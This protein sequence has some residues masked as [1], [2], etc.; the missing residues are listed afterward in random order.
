MKCK[1]IIFFIVFIVFICL[2]SFQVKA[3]E[4]SQSDE[5]HV[6]GAQV[7]SSG[8]AGIRFVGSVGEYDTSNVKTY[9]LILAYGKTE[10]EI[11]ID[12]VVNDKEVFC[13]ETDSVN[14]NGYYYVTLYDIP[15]TQYDVN[16]SAR[17]YV[18]DA[19]G[20]IIY[21]ASH[22]ARSLD[23]VVFKAYQ[24]NDRSD[25]VCE[26]YKLIE[27]L[28]EVDLV[29][30]GTVVTGYNGSREIIAIPE[31]VTEIGYGAFNGCETITNIGLPNNITSIGQY[32]FKNCIS[33]QSLTSLS[34]VESIGSYAFDECTSLT[35][36]YYKGT[37]EQW[38]NITFGNIDS[39]P[40]VYA[41]HF[42]MLDENNEWYEVT[43]IV[44]PE[45]VTEISKYAFSGFDNLISIEIPSSVTNI[46]RSAF[47]NC[48]SLINVKFEENSKLTSIGNYAFYACESLTNIEIP[49][50]VTNIGQS[51]FSNCAS[52]T[53]I[54]IPSSVTS[55]GNYAFKNCT[56]L[57]SVK[58]EDNSKLT[59]IGNYAFENCA[60]LINV[61]F[62]ENNILT[63][64]GDYAFRDCTGLTS[65][66]IPSSVI[67]IGSSAFYNCG[68]LINVYYKG[69]I[70]GWNAIT[71]ADA[72]ANP[73]YYA[74]NLYTLDENGE[75]V[76][77][78]QN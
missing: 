30:I 44:I 45:T 52:L 32:A 58:F 74:Q 50:S 4:L 6:I 49:S 8:N 72:Y 46:G 67:S 27:E 10:E 19:D 76:L 70:E 75:W 28:T 63:S 9:G 60:S 40:M 71:F 53:N 65:I 17:A 59:S 36:V 13:C 33:L 47:E 34:K 29:Y 51:T 3:N 23:E 14:E 18:K 78:I 43:E 64:I 16:V 31:K 62:E 5:I 41:S 39:Y 25:F 21:G 15:S 7:R 61:K 35:N 66:E 24:D 22:I 1:R 57:I 11:Y 37:M 73:M 55:I 42:Y 68:E 48:A 77:S 69:T 38:F 56:S 26:V 20:N 12:S 2:F 54:E